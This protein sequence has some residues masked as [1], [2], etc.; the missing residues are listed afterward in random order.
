MQ[1]TIELSIIQNFKE[2][3]KLASSWIGNSSVTHIYLMEKLGMSKSTFY[4][5]LK[6][7]E[8]TPDQLEGILKY[9]G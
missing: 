9:L 3:Q 6:D 1:T 8:W 7:C 4:R 2:L 5:R